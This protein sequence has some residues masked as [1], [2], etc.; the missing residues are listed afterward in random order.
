MLNQQLIQEEF[1]FFE[2]KVYLNI[3]SISMPPKRVQKVFSSFMS[4]YVHTLGCG[5]MPSQ[6]DMVGQT[7]PKIA[8]LINAEHSHEIAF[9]KNTCEGISIIANGY[10]LKAGENVVFADQEFQSSIYPWINIHKQK[11]IELKVVKSVDGQIPIQD[12]L[13]TIDENTRVLNV[14][15]TQFSTGFASDLKT[16]GEYCKERGIIFVVDAIQS[17]GR[18]SIDVQ[19]CNI[20]FLATGSHKGLL[21]TVGAGIIYCSDRIVND[22]KPSYASCQGIINHVNPPFVTTDFDT[23][24]FHPHAQK[25]ESGTLNFACIKAISTSVDFILELGTDNIDAHIRHLECSLREKIKDLKLHILQPHD[26]KNWGGII[27]VYF[28]DEHEG[29]VLEILGKYK[30]YSTVRGGCMRFGL[31]LFN[32]DEH[33]DILSKALHEIDNL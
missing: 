31:G 10:P 15:S 27:C 24:P 7:R 6:W 30:I 2:D 18:L 3:S 5:F 26:P 22:I 29:K 9:V 32:T 8:K 11:Q 12:V 33:M 25:F 21:A 19:E 17:L 13:S 20:D 23:L 1:D 14:S 4:D 16:L 28:P